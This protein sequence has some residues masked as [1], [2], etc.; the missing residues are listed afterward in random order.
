MAE[1][2]DHGS[3]LLELSL[4]VAAPTVAEPTVTNHAEFDDVRILVQEG[5]LDEAKRRI[6]ARLA[7]SPDW[8]QGRVLLEEIHERELED[9]L[10][11]PEIT[12]TRLPTLPPIQSL[13]D[14]LESDLGIL[15]SLF[16]EVPDGSTPEFVV[17]V[18]E[19]TQDFGPSMQQDLGIAFLEMGAFKL[20]GLLFQ[21]SS[22]QALKQDPVDHRRWASGR[23]L[24]L[25]ALIENQEASQAI[26][27]LLGLWTLDTLT[28]TERQDCARLL[29]KAYRR[30]GDLEHAERWEQL[31]N[32][33]EAV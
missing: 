10:R 15:P 25:L 16:P 21:R 13:V 22:V 31:V 17:A 2:E 5:L 6:R 28:E 14:R 32:R 12:Q 11:R 23:L 29:A 19:Q 3:D 20:A 27:E 30:T 24:E 26:P 4:Q 33:V 18:L 1:K 8:V 7:Q 9:L